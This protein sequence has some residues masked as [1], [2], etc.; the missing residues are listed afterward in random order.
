MLESGTGRLEQVDP[1]SGARNV[2]TASLKG[3]ARGLALHGS[4]GFIGLSKIR[5]TSA[6]DRVPLAEHRDQLKCG[7]VVV[8]LRTGGV[9]AGVD[10]ETAV[11]EV[12]DVQILIGQRFP[13]VVGFQK[14]TVQN[15]FVVPPGTPTADTQR[16][17]A[18]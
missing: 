7:V 8:D 3:F 9:I 5:P 14:D 4:Y 10:F 16:G 6:M 12:F 17:S 15:T 13:E 11:E 1:S 2:V 18:S